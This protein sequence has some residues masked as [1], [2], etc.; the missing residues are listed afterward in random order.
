MIYNLFIQ[1]FVELNPLYWNN[2][3]WANVAGG[4][5]PVSQPDAVVVT[6]PDV[7]WGVETEVNLTRRGLQVKYSS[8]IVF[9]LQRN[10]AALL[11]KV[12]VI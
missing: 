12:T 9:F 8:S 7:S 3:N 2:N 4:N 10:N 5:T 11:D 6:C 1:L